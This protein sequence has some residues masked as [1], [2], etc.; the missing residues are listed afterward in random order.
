MSILNGLLTING[1][2]IYEQ[3]GAFLAETAQ[4][5]HKNYDALLQ[6]PSLKKQAEVSISEEDG[7]RMAPK[8]VQTFEPRD[9]TLTFAIEAQSDEAFLRRYLSFVQFLKTG[10]DGWLDV[11]LSD[12]DM[13]F[14]VYL[15][16]AGDYSQLTPFGSASVVALFKVQLREPQPTFKPVQ[17]SR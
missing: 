8:L 2:D 1:T 10:N 13:T 7:V 6:M 5:E 11:H 12:L 16:G 15:K 9:I 17:T 3:F 4:D 14:R